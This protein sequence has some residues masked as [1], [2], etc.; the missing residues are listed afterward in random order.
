M[1]N[2]Y[3]PIEA[4]HPELHVDTR[5]N[6]LAPYLPAENPVLL[7]RGSMA[8]R[9]RVSGPHQ[10]PGQSGSDPEIGG[11]TDVR[12]VLEGTANGVGT[13]RLSLSPEPH[14]SWLFEHSAAPFALNWPE[15]VPPTRLSPAFASRAGA[16]GPPESRMVAPAAKGESRVM[17]PILVGDPDEPV[18]EMRFYLV[19]FQV[20]QLVDDVVRGGELDQKALLALRADDWEIEIERRVDFPQAMHHME[21]RRGYAVSHN[22]R[23]RRRDNQGHRSTFCFKEASGVLEA[24][25]LFASFVRGGM[26]GAALPVGYRD[27]VARAEQWHVTATDP[28]RYPDPHRSRPYHGWFIWYDGYGLEP[29]KR[30]GPLFSRFGDK[31]WDPDPELRSFWRNVLR[32]VIYAYT[33]AERMDENR[34]ITPTFTALETLSWALLVETERW[35]TGGRPS[36]GG[37][38]EYDRLTAAGQIRLLLRWAGIPAEVPSSLPIASQEAR[39]RNWDGPQIVAWVRNRVVHPDRRDQLIDGISAECTHLAMRYLELVLLKLLDYEGHY[40]DRLDAGKVKAVPW[41]SEP[42]SSP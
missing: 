23:L 25:R 33:D 10:G 36:D 5:E 30:L 2:Q 32:G 15:M 40:R 28:G 24:V 3:Q 21:E 41:T 1:A 19:N 26:V 35:L 22:C 27:D 11:S 37:D 6:N 38:N 16:N 4:P 29:A 8:G 12:Q 42:A 18:D 39:S 20:I 7:Y 34:A 17:R 9:W 13:V 31:W 14:I